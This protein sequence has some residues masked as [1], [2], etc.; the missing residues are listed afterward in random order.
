MIN[1]TLETIEQD[2]NEIKKEI[3]EKT[4]GYILTA[5]G[6]VAGLAWN[7]AIKSLIDFLF[8]L[9]GGDIWVKFIYAIIITLVVVIVSYKLVKI[10]GDKK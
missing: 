3:K 1:Q 8:P 10:I 5:L 4:L 6:L 9:S 2:K 7:E